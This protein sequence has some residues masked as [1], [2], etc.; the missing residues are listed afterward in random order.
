ML[1]NSDGKRFGASTYNSQCS[2]QHHLYT[3]YGKKQTTEF[4]EDMGLLFKSFKRRIT[5]EKQDG[6]GRIQTGKSPISFNLYRRINEY[7]L[8]EQTIESV[9]ARVFMNI[10]WILI[11]DQKILPQ[12]T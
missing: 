12:F 2:A 9:F 1:Q 11:V 5:E 8:R 3:L 7:V 4:K 6:D 10:T